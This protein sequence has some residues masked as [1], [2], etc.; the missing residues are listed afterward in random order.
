MSRPLSVSE[1]LDRAGLALEAVAT[2]TMLPG[3]IQSVQ[4]F[5]QA[6]AAVA[7]LIDADSEYDSARAAWLAD[8]SKHDKFLAAHTAWDRRAA[9]LARVKGEAA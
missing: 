6:R 5:E 2:A 1:I 7:E 8:H 4:D 9:A 3:D